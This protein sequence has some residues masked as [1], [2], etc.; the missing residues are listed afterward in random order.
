MSTL[1]RCGIAPSELEAL[2]MDRADWRSSCKSALEK[3]EIRCIQELESKWDLRKSGPPPTSN[4]E[5]QIC[6]WMCRSRIGLLAHKSHSWWW[7]TSRRRLSPY[8]YSRA[9]DL[10]FSWVE[11]VEFYVPLDTKSVVLEMSLQLRDQEFDSWP[12]QRDGQAK[13]VWIDGCMAR[14][15]SPHTLVTDSSLA[16]CR[17]T[18]WQKL[19]GYC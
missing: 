2:A 17:A 3:F 16:W 11:L 15:L 19:V 10:Q 6:H 7:D 5:C 1:Y 8:A 18:Y 14:R 12:A 4:F 13:F 9:S